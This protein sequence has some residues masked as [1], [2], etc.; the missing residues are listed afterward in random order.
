MNE[1]Q[2]IRERPDVVVYSDSEMFYLRDDDWDSV[3]G[4]NQAEA[5]K[6]FDAL[7]DWLNGLS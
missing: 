3:T 5:A 6:L 4:L 1:S 7:G 2:F